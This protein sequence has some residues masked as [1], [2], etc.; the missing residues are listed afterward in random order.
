[1]AAPYRLIGVE[2][3]P[4]SVKVRAVLRYRR[5]PCVWVSRMPQFFEE[6]RDVRPPLMPVLQYP[7]G[8]Y[9]VDSTPIVLDLEDRHPGRRSVLPEDPAAAF[10]CLL[11]EDLADEWLTKSLFHYRFAF[12]EGRRYGSTWVMD[13]AHPD[14]DGAALESK[15]AAFLERQLGRMPLVGCTPHN[16]PVLESGF[17]RVLD[18]LEPFVAN[19][20][21]LFGSRPSLADFA[22]FGQLRTLATDPV[23][24]ALFRERAPRTEHWVRRLDDT[25]GI[26]GAWDPADGPLRDAV[27][28]LLRLAGSTYLPYLRANARALEAGGDTVRVM[29]DGRPYEAPVFRYHGKCLASLRARYAALDDAT[30]RRLEAP[31]GDSGCL[32]A[33]AA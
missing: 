5:L 8:S 4:Y 21:F 19:E 27:M 17:E 14:L 3:S 18:A 13:D 10:A 1:M 12:G 20:R 30:R 11:I 32:E 29:L 15:A 16:A 7:D 28:S 9:H 6:T 22:L 33:L 26:E 25:S 24:L 31:L 2:S 23:P